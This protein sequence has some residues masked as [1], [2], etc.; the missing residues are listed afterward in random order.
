MTMNLR[1]FPFI[2]AVG[3]LLLAPL[4]Q[5]QLQIRGGARN[6]L[7]PRS[8]GASAVVSGGVVTGI[9]VRNGGAGYVSAPLVTISAG[10]GGTAYASAVVTD[11]KV[12][13]ITIN[14]GGLGYSADNPPSVTIAAPAIPTGEVPTTPQFAGVGGTST[15]AGAISGAGVPRSCSRR[16]SRSWDRVHGLPGM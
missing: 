16:S 9:T 13:A 4:A 10:V 1:F 12:T 6:V 8:A 11:G 5:A 3:A 15:G 14:S 2:A 7:D